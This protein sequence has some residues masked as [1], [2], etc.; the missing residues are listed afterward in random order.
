[1]GR[2]GSVAIALDDVGDLP[3]ARNISVAMTNDR[4]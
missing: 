1:M 3:L 2:V 4:W